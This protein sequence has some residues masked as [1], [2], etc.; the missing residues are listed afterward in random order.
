MTGQVWKTAFF[1]LL[2]L[3]LTSYLV[4]F[5][6]RFIYAI[7]DDYVEFPLEQQSRVLHHLA[8][9]S[10]KADEKFT[11]KRWLDVIRIVSPDAVVSEEKNYIL[12]NDHSY[13]FFENNYL[14]YVK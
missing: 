6:T 4:D 5:Y 1:I 9:L 12:V 13:F 7:S 2:A 14:V 10:I 11:R 8:E 3:V